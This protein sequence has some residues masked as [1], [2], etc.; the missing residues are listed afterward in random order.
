MTIKLGVVMDAIA[1]INYKKDSTLAMLWEAEKRGWEIYYFEQADLF[2]QDG[3]AYGDAKKLRVYHDEN[4]WYSCDDEQTILLE[5]LDVILMRKDPPLN[6]AYIHATQILE[7]AERAGTLVVNRPS[8]LRDCNEKLFACDFPG[9]MP[10]TLVTQSR[11]KFLT[12]WQEHQDVICKPLNT[13]GGDSVFRVRKDDVNANVI[14][15]VLTRRGSAQMMVQK[16]IPEI[17]FG[18][19]RILMI[20]G[21]AVP[22]LLARVPQD[23]DWRGNLAVGAKGQVRPL[24]ARDQFIAAQVGPILRERGIYFAGLDVIGDYLTEINITSPTCIREI[25]AGSDISVTQLLFD[26]IEKKLN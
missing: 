15:E 2:L 12:F 14:F 24:T 7:Y 17:A 4:N 9:C 25:E 26:V 10:A 22:A 16:F 21:E 18:D 11:E 20:N 5:E 8:A 1:S 19:K 13:M 23:G 6:E 3:F